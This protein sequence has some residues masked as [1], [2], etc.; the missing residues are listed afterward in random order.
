MRTSLPSHPR[1]LARQRPR[2]VSALAVATLGSAILA[3]PAQTL[4]QFDFNEG[5]GQTVTSAQGPLTGVLGRP[6]SSPVSVTDTPSGAAGDRALRITDPDGFLLLDA[7]GSEALAATDTPITVEAWIYL[8]EDAVP[9][10][11]AIVSYGNNWKFGLR[12]SGFIA[13][14]LYGVIDADIGLL[15]PLGVWTHVAVTWEPGVGVSFYQDGAYFGFLDETRPMRA[16]SNANLTVGGS[17]TFTEPVNATLDRVRVHRALLTEDQL[18]SVPG[19]PRAPLASTVVSLALNETAA[20]FANAGTLGGAAVEA[21]PVVLASISPRFVTDTPSGL[22]GDTAL[23]FDGN[24]IVRVDDPDSVV[25]LVTDGVTS[26]FTIQAWVKPG[27]PAAGQARSV[28]FGKFGVAGAF[29]FSITS[30]RRVAI[31]T[32]GIVDMLSDAAIPNDGLW[33]HIAVVHRNGQDMR[34]YVDGILGDTRPYTQGLNLRDQTWFWIGS[35]FGGGL[36]YTGLLDRL[37]LANVALEPA[38]LDFRA[39]PGVDP[40]A[41]ELTIG[42]AVSLAWPA[43]ATGFRLQSTTDL[44]EPRVWTDVAATGTVVGDTYYVLLPTPGQETYY[45]LIRPE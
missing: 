14:T 28:L 1:S 39:I 3:A 36:P 33:H 45:R 19:S 29:S 37:Q 8:P 18:D 23:Q 21:S 17:S 34:F 13:F 40:D 44:N 27:T 5:S 10:N 4:F 31:T 15:P 42:T 7:T 30:D 12:S 22:P 20:P 41:P 6:P 35:E 9:R 16:P 11:E 25:T 38:D 32:Y 24:D 26:D 2:W 43:T